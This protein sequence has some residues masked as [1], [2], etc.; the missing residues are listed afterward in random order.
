MLC[1][2]LLRR[3]QSLQRLFRYKQELLLD[4]SND[5][6][7]RVFKEAGITI[8]YLNVLSGPVLDSLYVRKFALESKPWFD[9]YIF[10]FRKPGEK[11]F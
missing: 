5:L 1:A 7:L 9:L 8:L 3:T 11:L 6:H 10:I 2:D 4:V